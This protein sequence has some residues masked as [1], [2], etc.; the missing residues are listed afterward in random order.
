MAQRRMFS[1]SITNSARFLK[2]PKEVQNLYFHLCMHADDD[3]I[4][5][6]FTVMQILG[7]EEDSIKLLAVKGF[8]KPLNEDLVTYILDWTEHN[9]IRADRKVDSIYKD[10]LLQ[11]V[12]EAEIVAPKPRADTKKLRGG[13]PM[14]VH[15]TAQDRIGEVSIVEKKDTQSVFGEM[16]NVR[17]T[18]EE[19]QKLTTR[20]GKSSVTILVDELST[21]MAAQNKRYSNHYATLL[22]WAKRK[23]LAEVKAPTVNQSVKE[24][25]EVT[26]EQIE[27]TAG[28][29][30]KVRESLPFL[31]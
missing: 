9:L 27:A 1:K 10:L 26:V 2:M 18:D 23:G 24:A 25:S 8:V 22:N 12:P 14:D 6:A 31:R 11:L 29:R 28:I 16:K 21:Y 19:Y 20:Y 5:E 7:A 13:Q 4:V 30:N 15:W 17:M 3:G